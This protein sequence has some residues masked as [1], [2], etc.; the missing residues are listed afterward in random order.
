M[1]IFVNFVFQNSEKLFWHAFRYKDN[2][3]KRLVTQNN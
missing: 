3:P 1:R 2:V